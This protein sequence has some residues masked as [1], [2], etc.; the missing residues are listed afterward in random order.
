MSLCPWV[1]LCAVT[2]ARGIVALVLSMTFWAIAPIALGW[3][4]TTVMTGSME[5]AIAPGDLVV[6][7]PIEIEDVRPGM[8][9]LGHD[10]DHHERLRLHRVV[11]QTGRA[12]ATKGDANPH[13]DSSP[14]DTA[15][16]LGVG[17]LRVPSIGAPILLVAEGKWGLLGLFALGAAVVV[18]L[19]TAPAV[20][21]DDQETQ[22]PPRG[23]RESSTRGLGERLLRRRSSARTDSPTSALTASIRRRKQVAAVAACAL[24]ASVPNAAPAG[25]AVFT[26]VSRTGSTFVAGT[27]QA[28]DSLTCR[29][30]PDGTASLT[31]TYTGDRPRDFDVLVDGRGSL[32]RLGPDA[33]EFVL[34][35]S[36]FVSLGRTSI[37]RIR[38]NL[39]REWT[40]TSSSSVSVTSAN[41]FWVG[42]VRCA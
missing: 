21:R 19:A 13:A 25:A 16:V 14:M 29:N 35:P 40:A 32:A 30:N 2:L 11:R 31:W 4:T 41:F 9:L 38:T 17:Y 26:S 5:P 18:S 34:R 22:P 27:A 7:R 36:G 42:V 23:P 10:P 6:S 8:V 39:T 15:A 20:R 1:R 33:R 12:I 3:T 24:I 37:V 28:A